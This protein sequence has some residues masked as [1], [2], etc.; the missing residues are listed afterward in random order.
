[1][2]AFS[3]DFSSLTQMS[4]DIQKIGE[5]IQKNESRAV[6]LGAQEYANDVKALAPYKTGTY[7]RS[8]HVDMTTEGI[9]KVALVGTDAPQARRLEYGFAG[10]DSLGRVYHQPPRPHWRPAWD[11]GLARYERILVAALEGRVEP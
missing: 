4:K 8:I 7:R 5:N 1:M 11:H 3:F 6:R 9:R 10:P 2:A